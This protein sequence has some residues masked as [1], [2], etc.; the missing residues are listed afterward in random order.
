MKARTHD[1][2]GA[3]YCPSAQHL[4]ASEHCIVWFPCLGQLVMRMHGLM[5]RCKTTTL[6]GYC[7]AVMGSTPHQDI[8]LQNTDARIQIPH[9]SAAK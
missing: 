7:A 1:Y 9:I 8:Y 4:A 5:Q 2:C 3:R 6:C